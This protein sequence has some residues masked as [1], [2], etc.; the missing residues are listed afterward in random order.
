MDSREKGRLTRT[1]NR[2]SSRRLLFPSV[3]RSSAP[4]SQSSA[5]DTPTGTRTKRTA[6]PR[7]KRNVCRAL[8][9]PSLAACDV[10]IDPQRYVGRKKPRY[11]G[12]RRLFPRMNQ[13]SRINRHPAMGAP[14]GAAFL[15]GA[16][17]C[18]KALV[19]NILSKT[20]A[21]VMIL[22][23]FA[24][25]AVATPVISEFMAANSSSLA[26]E[27]GAFSDWIEIFN[28]DTTPA[29]LAG[30]YLTDNANNTAKRQFPS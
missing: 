30:W 6:S 15:A 8:L 17:A 10:Q 24:S 13:L 21:A 28:P 26:D 22:A 27:D 5:E 16:H 11:R 19:N 7:R 25:P 1:Q 20:I 29:N 14:F 4:Q 23:A 9:H 18:S 12:S 2:R 3:E